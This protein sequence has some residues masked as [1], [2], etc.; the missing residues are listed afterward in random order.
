MASRSGMV[1][2]DSAKS[3]MPP[4]NTT[5]LMAQ[6]VF[7]LPS[8]SLIVASC[9]L[10]Q[11]VGQNQSSP[12]PIVTKLKIGWAVLHDHWHCSAADVAATDRRYWVGRETRGRGTAMLAM[13]GMETGRQSCN[14]LGWCTTRRRCKRSRSRSSL[15]QVVIARPAMPCHAMCGALLGVFARLVA[16]RHLLASHFN[17]RF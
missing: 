13:N 8:L 11:R 1:L 7:G 17:C 5:A 9:M 16:P 3:N 2:S 4:N 14:T 6:P 15:Q 10:A 12:K